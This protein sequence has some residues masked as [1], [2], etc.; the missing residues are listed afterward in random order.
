[1]NFRQ[2]YWDEPL[3]M[4]KR[5][6]PD[7]D[8]DLADL[9]PAKIRRDQLAI[10]NRSEHDV[11]RH[12]T[13]L[14]QMNF[15]IDTGFYPLG[16]C[17]MK[18]NPK[19]TEELAALPTVTRIHPDQDESTVQGALRVLYELQDL[20]ARIAGMDAITLQPA[21][22]A[23]GEYT[24]LLLAQAYHRERG[25]ERHEVIIP[26]TAHGTNPPSAGLLAVHPIETPPKD[27]RVDLK[28]LEAAAG[29][30]T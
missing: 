23:Q 27:G 1:M 24:G 20:L 2:A 9:V 13:R 22:G 26:D 15:G 4:E 5:S 12:F 11:V 8:V 18:F 29:P 3:L 25:E 30:S 19:F 7:T 14:S 16:S 28:A 10:P 6:A 17:T 21:A